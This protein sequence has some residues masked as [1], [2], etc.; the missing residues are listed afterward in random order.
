MDWRVDGSLLM[1]KKR[2]KGKQLYD[3]KW[4]QSIEVVTVT[5]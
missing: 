2:G 4:I 3:I 1:K 5:T